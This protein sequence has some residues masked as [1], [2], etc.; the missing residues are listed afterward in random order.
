MTA[1]DACYDCGECRDD[2]TD[3]DLGG[4]MTVQLC[5]ECKVKAR[6]RDE[7][8]PMRDPWE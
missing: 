8:G 2:L 5:P 1:H 6:E 3:Y 7:N 4:Y